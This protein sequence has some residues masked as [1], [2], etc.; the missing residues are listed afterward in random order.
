MVLEA[1][2]NCPLAW[3]AYYARE[4]ERYLPLAS[5]GTAV[6]FSDIQGKEVHDGLLSGSISVD[7][8]KA[9]IYP[10]FDGHLVLVPEASP[11]PIKAIEEIRALGIRSPLSHLKFRLHP[12]EHYLEATAGDL[13]TL[14]I[15]RN[16]LFGSFFTLDFSGILKRLAALCPHSDRGFLCD[17][18]RSYAMI[19]LGSAGH[20]ISLSG[21]RCLCVLYSHASGDAELIGTQVA[22][23]L[24]R[25]L[26]LSPEESPLARS[27][28]SKK[29]TDDDILTSVH[30]FA[31]GS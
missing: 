4:G 25:T 16:Y 6:T 18:L 23:T 12:A 3:A 19:I 14:G 22:K 20:A 5:F 31:D 8:A 30:S 21:D 26:E 29:L 28:L 15:S 11:L 24:A 1:L 7:S 13:A 27:F 9:R 10:V 2:G 17:E